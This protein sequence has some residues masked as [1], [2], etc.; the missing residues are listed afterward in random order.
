MTTKGRSTGNSKGESSGEDAFIHR[1][2][3]STPAWKQCQ[4]LISSG[5][6]RNSSAVPNF[7]HS[8]VNLLNVNNVVAV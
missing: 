2:R 5:M 8:L 1:Q 6:I 3:E 4:P 7:R